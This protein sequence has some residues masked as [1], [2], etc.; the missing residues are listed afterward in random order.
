MNDRRIEAAAE[1]LL[2]T[3]SKIEIIA[4]NSGFLSRSNFYREFQGV[5]GITPAAYRKAGEAGKSDI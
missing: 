3:N 1:A 2:T 4:Q 5:H